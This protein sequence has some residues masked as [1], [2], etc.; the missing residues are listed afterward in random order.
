MD[1][2]LKYHIFKSYQVFASPLYICS[3]QARDLSVTWRQLTVYIC[4]FIRFTGFRLQHSGTERLC[5]PEEHFLIGKCFCSAA[6][7]Q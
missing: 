7:W 1:A 2:L 5:Y 3:L 4:A 6:Y